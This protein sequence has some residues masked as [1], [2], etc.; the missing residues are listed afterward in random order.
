LLIERTGSLVDQLEVIDKIGTSAVN[1][2]VPPP[3]PTNMATAPPILISSHEADIHE[4]TRVGM[5]LVRQA[6]DELDLDSKFDAQPQNQKAF[7]HEITERAIDCCW[8]A[9]GILSY[10]VDT[11]AMDLLDDHG[12]IPLQALKDAATAALAGTDATSLRRKQ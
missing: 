12:K 10:M 3:A 2:S 7:L 8:E 4:T 6:T 5:S 9:H 1:P 11:Q